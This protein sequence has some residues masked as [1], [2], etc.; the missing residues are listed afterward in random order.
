MGLTES[1]SRHHDASPVT[2]PMTTTPSTIMM[3]TCLIVL[4]AAA[5][6][7]AF[8]ID[9]VQQILPTAYATDADCEAGS[10]CQKANL[11]RRSL[12][13]N[14][15]CTAVSVFGE[16]CYIHGSCGC[17]SGLSCIQDDLALDLLHLNPVGTCGI[18]DSA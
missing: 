13:D 3:K 2:L 15:V 12:L 6:A 8:L 5:C 4:L 7:N 17:A 14:G 10:C 9:T 18:P 11:G 16:K 1:P